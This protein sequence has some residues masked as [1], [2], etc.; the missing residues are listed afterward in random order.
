[1]GGERERDD[2]RKKGRMQWRTSESNGA[3]ITLR[4]KEEREREKRRRDEGGE[5]AT[6]AAKC[7]CPAFVTL[8]V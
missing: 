3:G 6:L 2:T 5:K 1:M 7:K 8:P 4:R